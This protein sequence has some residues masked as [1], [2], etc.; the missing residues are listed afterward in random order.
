MESRIKILCKA[1]ILVKVATA[2]DTLNSLNVESLDSEMV[3]DMA[4]GSCDHE[5]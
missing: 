1:A 2:M 4:Y 5:I 3:L